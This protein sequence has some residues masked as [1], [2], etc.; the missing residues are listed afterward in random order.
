[1]ATPP[2]NSLVEGEALTDIGKN[3]EAI[4]QVKGALGNAPTPPQRLERGLLKPWARRASN[5]V[6]HPPGLRGTLAFQC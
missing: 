1:M 4:T 2:C 3:T 5:I 6:T